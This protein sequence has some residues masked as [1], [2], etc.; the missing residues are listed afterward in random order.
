MTIAKKHEP[1]IPGGLKFAQPGGDFKNFEIGNVFEAYIAGGYG[2]NPTVGGDEFRIVRQSS[3]CNEAK[4][5]DIMVDK[6]LSSLM[7]AIYRYAN[8]YAE[9]KMG[10]S[11][12]GGYHMRIRK[13]KLSKSGTFKFC[14]KLQGKSFVAHTNLLEYASTCKSRAVSPKNGREM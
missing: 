12:V 14:Y 11:Q 6:P 3:D 9:G 7:T 1:V 2:L 5:D 13:T 10:D 4:D 8:A